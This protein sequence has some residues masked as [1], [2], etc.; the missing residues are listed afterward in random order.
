MAP[1]GRV[2]GEKRREVEERLRIRPALSYEVVREEGEEELQ[3]GFRALWW[4]GLAAGLSAGFSLIATGLLYAYLPPEA[5]AAPLVAFGYCAGFL[6][7]VLGRQQLFTENTITALLPVMSE[8]S[9]VDL[10]AML[11]LWGIVL[12]ANLVGALLI[13]VALALGQAFP[14]HVLDAFVSVSRGYLENTGMT[15]FTGA[16][17]AG[18]LVAAM[19]WVMPTVPNSRFVVVV[20]FT[21]M[22]GLG[23]LPHI[24]VGSVNTLLLAVLGEAEAS[25]VILR[26]MLPTLLGNVIGGSALFALITYAQ[27]RE[28]V[29]NNG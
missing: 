20:F 9:R 10:L 6:I 25:Q 8:R 4:S 1:D 24:I 23:H 22:I 17:F 3:R 11:R 27:V 7:V 29:E 28:E 12:L 26:F 15:N 5:W 18:W 21:W 2:E 16:I 14:E 19:V 13:A